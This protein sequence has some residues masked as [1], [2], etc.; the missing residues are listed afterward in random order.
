M[1]CENYNRNSLYHKQNKI[2]VPNN[3][4]YDD[5]KVYYD[6][7][8]GNIKSAKDKIDGIGSI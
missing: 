1:K 4:F 7:I 6:K 8:D 2:Y 5:S 3:I